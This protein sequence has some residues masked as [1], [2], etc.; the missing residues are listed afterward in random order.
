[1]CVCVCVCV[2]VRVCVCMCAS[3]CVCVCVL[4]CVCVCVVC[5]CSC[6]TTFK[7]G[8]RDFTSDSWI[9]TINSCSYG[10]TKLSFDHKTKSTI[11]R[12]QCKS[13]TCLIDYLLQKQF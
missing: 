5:V 6:H 7:Y 13:M 10:D 4:V 11:T 8:F 1:M 3:V 12:L 9:F 2:C